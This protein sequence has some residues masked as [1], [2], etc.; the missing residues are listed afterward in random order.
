[1]VSN[2]GTDWVTNV[3]PVIVAAGFA[4][5]GFLI[6]S[7]VGSVTKNLERLETSFTRVT[8]DLAAQHAALE[9]RA[10][11]MDRRLVRVESWKEL[12]SLPDMGGRQRRISDR[13]FQEERESGDG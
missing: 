4:G 2:G 11:N 10:D 6:R 1:M 12:V 5:V 9:Q 13:V 8:A 7:A 3:I